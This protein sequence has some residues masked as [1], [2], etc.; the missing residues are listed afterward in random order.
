MQNRLVLTGIPSTVPT[1][2][3]AINSLRDLVEEHACWVDRFI[4]LPT[5]TNT[6]DKD[7]ENENENENESTV[8]AAAELHIEN[9]RDRAIRSLDRLTVLLTSSGDVHAS[10]KHNH[11]TDNENEDDNDNEWAES[12]N[13]TKLLSFQI[14]AFPANVTQSERLIELCSSLDS[15]LEDTAADK[16][17]ENQ[18]LKLPCDIELVVQRSNEA[19]GTGTNP[20]RGGVILA[21]QICVWFKFMLID[22]EKEKL[23]N[24]NQYEYTSTGT[25]THTTGRGVDFKSL[26]EH[27]IVL[28]L[29]AGSAGLPC[30]ALGQIVKHHKCDINLISSDGIDEIVTALKRNISENHLDEFV[31]VQHIDWNNLPELSFSKHQHQRQ[32]QHQR[33]G[34]IK[35]DTIIFADCVYNEEGA[36][37]LFNAICAFLKRKGNVVGVLPDFRVGLDLFEKLME[38]NNFEPTVIPHGELSSGHGNYFTCSGGGGKN[39]RLIHWIDKRPEG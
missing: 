20:W 35:A 24:E 26:F 16:K 11:G 17:M 29:G 5:N 15:D 28:E 27:R 1:L 25:G 12:K 31:E 21:T 22:T 37:A 33:H 14:R 10:H 36:I 7:N 23:D 39:Y 18:L 19:G 38:A 9:V 3:N 32:R 13:G 8:V 6:D 30:M 2:P 34:A 4:F